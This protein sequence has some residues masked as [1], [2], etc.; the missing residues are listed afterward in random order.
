MGAPAGDNPGHGGNPG[1]V[2]VIDEEADAELTTYADGAVSEVMHIARTM[3]GKLI[4]KGGATIMG[5]QSSTGCSIQVDQHTATRGGECRR[6][7]LKGTPSAVEAA[8]KAVRDALEAEPGAPSGGEMSSDL[9]CP[10][11]VVGRIIGRAGET[12]KLL[13]GASG[14]YILVNQNFPDGVDR[15]ITIS[16]ST[17]AVGRAS[18]MVRDLISSDL[19]TV[20][21]VIQK[22][23]G[24]AGAREGKEAGRRA[25]PWLV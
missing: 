20:Q 12:I 22:V 7:T 8:K 2:S 14:A 25:W 15:V 6:V 24:G 18:S 11:H 23:Q 9:S 21:S 19:I 10:Q 16:G 1:G 3:V 13:Q 17:D 5:L 4:G